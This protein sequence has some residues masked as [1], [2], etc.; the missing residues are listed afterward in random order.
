MN[1]KILKYLILMVL[2]L[3]PSTVGLGQSGGGW[4]PL[5][6]VGVISQNYGLV[7]GRITA[8][9]LDSSDTTG[10][11][12]FVGTTGGGVWKSQNAGTSNTSEIVFTVRTDELPALS[13][14]L[15]ASISIGAL[16]VQPG[17]TGVVLAGTGD[18]N[19]ALDSYYGAGI[20]RS[21]DGGTTWSLIPGTIDGRFLF[22]GES[23]AGF[24]WG[25]MPSGIT[26]CGSNALSSEV[27]VAAVS[28]AYE[29][30]LVNAL[31]AG[32]SYEGLYYSTD[33]GQSWCLST[34]TDSTGYDVQGPTDLFVTPDGNAATTVVWN[35]IRKLFIAAV[36]YHG[37]Y[38]STNGITWTRMAAQPGTGLLASANLCPTNLGEIGNLSCPIFRGTLAVNPQTGDTFA[39]TVDEYNQDQGIWM[40]QCEP[41]AN[42]C[43]NQSITFSY[44]LSTSSLESNTLQ[45]PATIENGDYNLALAAV[46]SGQE[47][48]LLAG[49]NDL[50]QCYLTDSQFPGCVWRNT[51]NSTVGFCAQVGEYQHA[52][53]WNASNEQEIFI[54][55]DSGLWRSA[56]AIGEST[57]ANPEPVCSATD[58]THFQNLNGSL[59]SLGEVVSLSQTGST[60]YTMMASLGTIGTAG[61]NSGSGPTTDWPETLGGEGGP[62]AIDPV[63]SLNWYVNNGAGVSIYKG[64]PPTG[65]TPGAFAAVLTAGTE[66]GAAVV[67]DG[68]TMYEPA[69]FLVDP[70]DHTQL[71][72]GTCRVWRGPANGLDWSTAN[73]ISPILDDGSANATCDGDAQIRS[74]A[75]LELPVSA[76]LPKG[77]EIVYV[78]MYSTANGGASLPGHVLSATVNFASAMMPTWTDLTLN[79]VTNDQRTMNYFG[80][81]ITSIVVDPHDLTGQTVYVT[82]AGFPTAL[83]KIQT[84]Y[85]STD[86]GAH[87]ASLMSNLPAAPANGLAVDPLDARTVYVA[88][89]AGVY[90]TR[91]IANCA[92]VVDCWS[93]Y[94]SGLPL[95][96]VVQISAAP[97]T[98]SVHNLVV[99]TYGRGIWMTPLWTAT[100]ETTTAM[101]ST[102][103]LTFASQVYGTTSGAQPVTVTNTGSLALTTSYVQATGEF[104]ASGNCAGST[105]QPGQSCTVEVSFTPQGVGPRPQ[106]TLTIYTNVAGGEL[107]VT[108]SGTGAPSGAVSLTPSAINLNFN[109]SGVATNGILVGQSSGTQ[110]VTASNSGSPALPFTSAISGPFSIVTNSCG[111]SIPADGSCNLTLTFTP[112]QAGAASGSLTFTDASGTQTVALSG[113]GLSPATDTVSSNSLTFPATIDGQLSAAQTVTLTNNGGVNLTS[114][115]VSVS[116]TNAADFQVTNSCTQILGPGLPCSISVQFDPSVNGAETASLTIASSASDSPQTVAL[117]G[118]GL[119][120]PSFGVNPSSLTFAAQT[121]G[122]S[123]APQT[124]T[125]TNTGGAT[126]ANVGFWFSASGFTMGTN[127]CGATLASGANCTVQIIFSPVAAGGSSATLVIS[128]SNTTPNQVSVALNGAGL[129]PAGVNI[130]PAQIAFPITLAGQSSLS[131]TPVTLTNTGQS[132]TNALSL[133]ATSPFGLVLNTCQGTTLAPGRSCTVWVNFTPQV[134]GSYSGTMTVQSPAASVALS[135]TGGVPGSVSFLP[136]L[137]SFMQTGV[138][139]T[140]GPSTVTITNPDGVTTLNSLA[141]Q[142]TAGFQLLSTTC[143]TTLGPGASCTATIEFAPVSA[144]AQT[145]ALTVTSGALPTGSFMTL[146]GVGFDFTFTPSGSATQAVASGQV[147]NFNLLIEPLNGS[148]GVFSFQCGTLP[149]S[150]TCKFNPATEN[151][152]PNGIGNVEVEIATEITQTNARS[153]PRPGPPSAWPALSLACGLAV[154][155][156][157]LRRRRREL[158]LV[159]LLVVLVGGVS[160]CT[161][162]SVGLGTN[163]VL[164]KTTTGTTPA[165]TYQIVVTASSVSASSTSVSHQI[166]LTLTVD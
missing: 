14:V 132:S 90:S 157:A 130:S 113:T 110:Q 10:N 40:D 36:R 16:S 166:T 18:P 12:L 15:D 30:T 129:T 42:A 142:V 144:G 46:P 22:A 50:W 25:T 140:S 63:N 65:S 105:V 24:A 38:Q 114:I 64:T 76:T 80:M 128:S 74:M 70:A 92:N 102:S 147:A 68:Y 85:G 45:G 61:V 97:A 164:S 95:S 17:G 155:P 73:A 53:E 99:G 1:E 7:T 146:S 56:D 81:D 109:A 156:F 107:T 108:L 55:N 87:W 47:T 141:V 116:G 2:T 13:G 60:P 149:P 96:P 123:S 112:T 133:S 137:L 162:S 75:V 136:S 135:G 122:Q 88:T 34:I 78:G 62:V 35:P 161:Q 84:L 125:V 163:T 111:S 23:V 33:N 154:L 31:G 20:L 44:K 138:G 19:D 104:S 145:G 94:G 120:P 71:L 37:Y 57:V 103:A 89:D 72:I 77:G 43:G 69:P 79:P 93:A 39:W 5:G 51:T 83:T 159:A 8:L 143:P 67:E 21:A 6:P 48:M 151:V 153:L 86:G 118:A 52:L 9:A 100:E 139:Q 82:L 115:S 27:V 29:G 127:T 165:A 41:S 32:G 54:G 49:A 4:Q 26:A 3:L 28:Q 124:V 131:P 117:S 91:A 119:A 160:S 158:L 148:R 152:P 101:L 59:G 58:A 106:G 150:T 11:T 126:A 98:A 66:P 121:V 134:N